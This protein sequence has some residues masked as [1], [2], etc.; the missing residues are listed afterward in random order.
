[1]KTIFISTILMLLLLFPLS[2]INSLMAQAE[3]EGEVTDTA[4]L[5][6]F[7]LFPDYDPFQST[8]PIR[9]VL[10][11][12]LRELRRN[13]ASEE[14]QD[15]ILRWIRTD[16]ETEEFNLK[17]KARGEFRKQHC[18]LLPPITL[19]F[20]K[21]ELDQD[22]MNNVNKLKLVTHCQNSSTYQQ[23]LFKEYLT[24]RMFNLLTDNSFRVRLYIIE[25][26]DTR[27]KRKPK[28]PIENYGFIIESNSLLSS[29]LNGIIIERTGINSWNT[30][31]YQT[32]LMSIFQYMIGNTDWN[33]EFLHN[34]RLISP[35]PVNPELVEIKNPIAI[36][37]D[38]DY[39][40]MVDASYATPDKLLEI[41]SVRTRVYRG[42]CLIPEEEYQEYFQKF[43]DVKEELYALVLNFEF[44]D[45]RNRDEMIDYLDS[46]YEIIGDPRLARRNIISQCL[47]LAPR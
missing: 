23:Y 38:F 9:M 29:R 12:D 42:I 33:F 20:K 21:S 14:Y 47:P 5:I 2:L 31:T 35:I 8:E 7:E 16:G 13:K 27:K 45:N 32:M 15:A 36:P 28:E 17:I 1:M 26:R 43:L 37:F 3:G 4:D 40:G 39:S 30:D 22:Y 25:Y 34:I 24:Y 44:L 18:T 46:F 6:R 10:E 19:N 11:F 41:E